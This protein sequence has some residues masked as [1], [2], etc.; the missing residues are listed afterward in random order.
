MA[1]RQLAL[2]LASALL[3]VADAFFVSP[4]SLHSRA[5]VSGRVHAGG[6][7]PLG[8]R[9]AVL[10]KML[11]GR[12]LSLQ[13]PRMTVVGDASPGVSEEASGVTFSPIA[14]RK[15]WYPVAMEEFTTKD[16]PFAFT[17][18][19]TK[20][21][22]WFDLVAQEWRAVN[23][24][25]PHRLAPLSEGRVNAAGDIECPY[26][27]WAFSGAD[28][29]CTTMPQKPKDDA[30]PAKACV[31]TYATARQD[32]M[33]WVWA[34]EVLP[35]SPLP[36]TEL[37]HTI[38]AM[39]DGHRA[40]HSIS[41]ENFF[42]DLPYDATM[43]VENV[44]DVSHVAFT[45][46]K[47]QGLRQFAAPVAYKLE[48]PITMGGFVT[49]QNSSSTWTDSD[50]RVR[51]LQTIFDAPHYQHTR[52]PIMG[53][54]AAAYLGTYATPTTPGRSRL[55][56]RLVTEDIPKVFQTIKTIQ[57][58]FK[59]KFL[60][61]HM[62]LSVLEDDNIFLHVQ[63]R[64]LAIK[65]GAN[66]A[67]GA[68]AWGKKLSDGEMDAAANKWAQSY[69]LPTLSDSPVISYRRWLAKAGPIDWAPGTNLNLGE[70]QSREELMERY[71]THVEHCSLCKE[72]LA[73]VKTSR[74]V[75][76]VAVPV[77]ALTGRAI[78]QV[79]FPELGWWKA[80][81]VAWSLAGAGGAAWAVLGKWQKGFYKG[82]Y[83]PPR[84]QGPA[85]GP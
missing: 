53:G 84:N 50:I 18:L 52:L 15:H 80:A 59:P 39:T 60:Q 62:R 8:G 7:A 17:L 11:T 70:P 37:I 57:E 49:L 31:S 56:L 68:T 85:G 10:S 64:E 40:K 66:M 26:H 65:T 42:A 78:L 6:S 61:H 28:G 51:P 47:T 9:S 44:I 72:S 16:T 67:T 74:N 1:Q 77:V 3:V 38:E 29:T 82:T 13:A 23:D 27:G 83:P 4:P 32:G 73:R 20:L 5:A 46:H 79:V 22:I 34:D 14:W 35:G 69:L 25:C 33:I 21:V 63:E 36:S 76:A 19:G 58:L 48:A 75:L 71:L 12:P 43:A 2:A 30:M 41:V 24:K 55:F 45:H 54:K 81:G